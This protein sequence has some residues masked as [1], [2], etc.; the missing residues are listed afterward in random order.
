MS[1]TIDLVWVGG[2]QPPPWPLG[3]SACCEA[4]PA[5]VSG[6]CSALESSSSDATLFWGARLGSPD[7]DRVQ[8]ALARPGDVWHAGL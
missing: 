3:R 2:V 5:G 8:E 7:P 4:S 1:P 6:A